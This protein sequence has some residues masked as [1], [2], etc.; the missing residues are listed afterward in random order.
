MANL[1][2]QNSELRADRIWNWTLPAWVTK[3]PDGSNLNV[4]PS[5]GAC[6][7]VCYARNGTFN[8]KN[9]KEAHTRNLVMVKD[10]LPE[11]GAAMRK[12][13]SHKRFAMSQKPRFNQEELDRLQLDSWTSIWA[14]EGG[15]AV[16]IHD[17]GDFFSSEYLLEWL[18]IAR[19]FPTILF[20]AYTK[21]VLKFRELVEG[22]AP[23][24]FKWVYSM[25]G[26]Y[27]SLIN[28]DKERH[29]DVF[30]TMEMLENAGYTAQTDNDLYAVLLP[31][32][33]IG[34]PANNIPAFKKIMQ[35]RSFSEIQKNRQVH[36]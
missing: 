17:S 28:L 26:K 22:K 21:E 24:N 32:T 10:N 15:A 11:W 35:G 31:T 12:E 27:D 4:C 3:M 25:G 14:N 36:D 23:N 7:K 18:A 19:D 8:F 16:R 1:L 6:A 33:R 2:K 30:P 5:A 29:A 34:V 9:V 13:L 20:Y